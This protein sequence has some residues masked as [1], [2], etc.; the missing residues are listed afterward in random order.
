MVDRRHGR[1]PTR[2][3]RELK[4]RPALDPATT[5]VGRRL[6]RAARFGPEGEGA[7]H[8]VDLRAFNFAASVLGLAKELPPELPRFVVDAL[9]EQGARLGEEVWEAHH[10]ASRR[11]FLSALTSARHAAQRVQYWLRLIGTDPGAPAGAIE[12]LVIRA[13]ELHEILSLMCAKARQGLENEGEG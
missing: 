13:R 11:A 5:V 9:L 12:D 4:T 3:T 10:T 6:A 1:R 2:Q 7:P 8:Q